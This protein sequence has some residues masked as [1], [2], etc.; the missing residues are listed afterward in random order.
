MTITTKIFGDFTVKR[1]YREGVYNISVKNPD[2]VEKGIKKMIVD[3][4][5]INGNII[6]YDKNKKEI[7]VE[8]I[9]G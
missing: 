9:M 3:G 6:P 1:A 2:N 4:Q 7:N 8:V 5:E